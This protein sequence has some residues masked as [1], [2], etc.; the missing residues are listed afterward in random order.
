MY[1][2]LIVERGYI[3]E[4]DDEYGPAFSSEK[5]AKHYLKFIAA[6]LGDEYDETLYKIEKFKV[7]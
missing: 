3:P 1:V 7:H 2:Y 6:N 4:A 5:K